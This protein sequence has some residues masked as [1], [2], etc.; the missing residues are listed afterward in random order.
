MANEAHSVRAERAWG[1]LW[2]SRPQ[3]TGATALHDVGPVR[4]VRAFHEL[5]THHTYLPVA[6]VLLSSQISW[7]WLR[8][9]LEEVTPSD[10]RV[11]R[12][13]LCKHKST[14]ATGRYV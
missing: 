5:A 6:P 8:W 2:R 3:T 9:P 1:G 11:H 7:R 14:G 12:H 4:H 10:Y 13:D